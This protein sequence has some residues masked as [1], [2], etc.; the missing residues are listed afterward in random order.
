MMG[1]THAACQAVSVVT[2]LYY[3]S[4][5]DAQEDLVEDGCTSAETLSDG[6]VYCEEDNP[7][8]ADLAE[9]QEDLDAVSGLSDNCEGAWGALFDVYMECRDERSD[10]RRERDD[11][12]SRLN[13]ICQATSN[14]EIREIA[15]CAP[16]LVESTSSVPTLNLNQTIIELKTPQK[17]KK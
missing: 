13:R 11:L 2:G 9:C 17:K 1:R 6:Y 7:L 4:D 3:C 5:S 14:A 8:S 12:R 15:G 10:Y 16:M